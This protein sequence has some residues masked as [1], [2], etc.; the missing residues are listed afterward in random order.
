MTRI[1]P[2]DNPNSALTD[3]ADESLVCGSGRHSIRVQNSVFPT[4]CSEPCEPSAKL[5]RVL[6][7]ACA[8]LRLQ[9]LIKLLGRD[10]DTLPA[11][12]SALS[13][14]YC[15]V[16]LW[17]GYAAPG[18]FWTTALHVRRYGTAHNR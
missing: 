10:L 4:M 9:R 12:C 15:F 2:Y 13:Y 5:T 1:I 6:G 16:A 3:T 17:T 7:A 14:A 11:T 8:T 18:R